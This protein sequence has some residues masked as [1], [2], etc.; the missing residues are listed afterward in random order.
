MVLV[1]PYSGYRLQH[2]NTVACECISTMNNHSLPAL[3]IRNYGCLSGSLASISTSVTAY[4][5]LTSF[6][7]VGAPCRSTFR[8]QT[9]LRHALFFE[10]ELWFKFFCIKLLHPRA[11]TF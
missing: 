7:A 11:T 6:L 1:F 5:V 2:L 9:T 3:V 4:E 10:F 8:L